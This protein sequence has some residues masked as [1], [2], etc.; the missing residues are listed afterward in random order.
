MK[1]CL[2]ITGGS[3][4]I[5]TASDYL[6]KYTYDIVIAVD[7][8]LSAARKLQLKPDFCVG[9]FDSVSQESYAYFRGQEGIHW[10]VHPPEKNETDTELGLHLALRQGAKEIHVFGATGTRMDH[11]LASI[12][13]LQIPLTAGAQCWLIDGHNR[14]TML[15]SN[16][17]LIKAEA[18][19][20]YV[21]LIP[22]TESVSGVTLT[23]MKYPLKDY[24]LV[25]G[26]SLGISNEIL[27]QRACISLKSGKLILIESL[28]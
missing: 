22:Y 23:G 9:D 20:K 17:S 7:G 10:E 18:F 11:T 2:I 25:Q 4:D 15:D 13:L 19:G 6:K 3:V 1:R 28:D 21:S 8:G 14:I 24:T 26:N 5:P 12:G 27:E 16:I